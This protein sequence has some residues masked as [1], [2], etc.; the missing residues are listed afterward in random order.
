MLVWSQKTWRYA[1]QL[2]QVG[3][4]DLSCR[5]CGWTWEL[6]PRLQTGGGDLVS[7]RWLCQ[8]CSS[9]ERAECGSLH[10]LRLGPARTPWGSEVPGITDEKLNSFPQWKLSRGWK[11]S[12][13]YKEAMLSADPQ[14]L[15]T[16]STDQMEED[17]STQTTQHV[18]CLRFQFRVNW[19]FTWGCGV[20]FNLTKLTEG[21]LKNILC[22]IK[23]DY[24][25]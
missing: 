16:V 4:G 14:V 21:W 1:A 10:G 25:N 24:R 15:K 6:T 18:L 5:Y 9:C 7:Q 13:N 20:I 19:L 3:K 11:A 8:P 2:C 12:S 17:G 23:L 22:S